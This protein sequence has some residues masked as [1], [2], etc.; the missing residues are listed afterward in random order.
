MSFIDAA[1]PGVIGLICLAAPKLMVKLGDDPAANER[2]V[3]KI[4]LCGG[5]LLVVA[6]I[7]MAAKLLAPAAK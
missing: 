5:L 7:Y 4:R 1:I 6:A 2:K 3:T